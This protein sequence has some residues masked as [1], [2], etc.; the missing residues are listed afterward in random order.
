MPFVCL[1]LYI[2]VD[3]TPQMFQR[4]LQLHGCT[5]PQGWT[6]QPARQFSE[7]LIP[8]PWAPAVP[9]AGIFLQRHLFSV[10]FLGEFLGL[11]ENKFWQLLDKGYRRRKFQTL[12]MWKCLISSSLF[13]SGLAR[14][15]HVGSH[16][17]PIFW[18]QCSSGDP[19][20]SLKPSWFLT[21]PGLGFFSLETFSISGS[22]S[23]RRFV[24]MRLRSCSS[25][26]LGLGSANSLNLESHSH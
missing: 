7:D 12:H 8:Q 19:W 17:S 13:T 4:T 18:S 10:T 22:L 15:F 5:P 23:F 16:L 1:F 11:V 6:R 3:E 26:V 24:A 25:V 2:T 20:T 9:G 21:L 14:D